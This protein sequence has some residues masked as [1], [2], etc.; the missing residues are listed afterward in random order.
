MHLI[1][2]ILHNNKEIFVSYKIVDTLKISIDTS[3]LSD[4]EKPIN[5]LIE[6]DDANDLTHNVF[7]YGTEINDFHTLN[8][9]A[10]WTVASAALQEVDRIQQADAVKIQ[11]LEDKV[12][13][14]ETKNFELESQLT[15]ILNRLSALENNN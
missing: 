13:I 4:D 8:K 6:D 2:L 12:S 7:V 11:T 15:N 5:G 14:L 10:I 1:K 9:N 3:N